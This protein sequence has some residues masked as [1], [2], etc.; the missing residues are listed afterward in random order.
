MWTRL[1][2]VAGIDDVRITAKTDA[3]LRSAA[4][5]AAAILASSSPRGREPAAV[6]QALRAAHAAL[7]FES[8]RKID[9]WSLLAPP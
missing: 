3:L 8:S 9:R 2:A 6:E 1:R 7:A 4:L 5:R